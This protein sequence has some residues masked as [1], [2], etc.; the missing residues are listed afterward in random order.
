MTIQGEY[1]TVSFCYRLPYSS[2]TFFTAART[3]VSAGCVMTGPLTYYDVPIADALDGGDP[4]SFTPPENAGEDWLREIEAKV[5]DYPPCD[6]ALRYGDWPLR[7]SVCSFFEGSYG[8]TLDTSY[9][10]FVLE[11]SGQHVGGLAD[12]GLRVCS[13]TEALYGMVGHEA[14]VPDLSALRRGQGLPENWAYI[15]A[16]FMQTPAGASLRATITDLARVRSGTEGDTFWA[17]S[18]WEAPVDDDRLGQ[19]RTTLQPLSGLIIGD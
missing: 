8:L 9:E 6:V 4:V 1:L 7:L 15:G 13:S 17:L 3:L 12:L 19:I 16:K 10:M 14:H 11:E 5:P 18:A 2:A